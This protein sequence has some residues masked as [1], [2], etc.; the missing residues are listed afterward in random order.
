MLLAAHRAEA[1]KL[2]SVVWVILDVRE[3][4]EPSDRACLSPVTHRADGNKFGSVIWV[5]LVE[6][7]EVE[8][9]ELVTFSLVSKGLRLEVV[10]V[11]TDW[12]VAVSVSL[13]HLWWP[14]LMWDFP[15][16]GKEWLRICDFAM[17]SK[18]LQNMHPFGC[19]IEARILL[20]LF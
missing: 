8:N 7:Q 12:L 19:V 11:V 14:G 2:C 13:G 10:M 4:G 9:G 1:N 6:V 3:L 15:M 17:E 18:E 20:L 5:R 16:D